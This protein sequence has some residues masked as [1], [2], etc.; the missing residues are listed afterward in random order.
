MNFRDLSSCAVFVVGVIVC[1]PVAAQTVTNFDYFG[2]ELRK[3]EAGYEE[4]AK[5]DGTIIYKYPGREKAVLKDGTVIERYPDGKREIKVPDGR[6]LV[7][8]FDGTR[9]YRS[10]GGAERTI[11]LDGKTPWGDPISPSETV[12]SLGGARVVL[13]FDPMVSDDHLDGAAK[14][15]FDELAAVLRAKMTSL[16]PVEGFE[17]R[18][19]VSQCRFARTGHCRR[20]NAQELEARIIAGGRERASMSLPYPSMLKD[21]ERSAF[22][23]RV[24]K[25]LFGD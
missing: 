11:S 15:F 17:G 6:S 23:G 19:V 25:G 20:K 13:V 5:P 10:P 16:K 22:A 21:D 18:I 1:R 12:I 2:A 8:E 9:H 3:K 4:Y 24:A 14:K 7:I